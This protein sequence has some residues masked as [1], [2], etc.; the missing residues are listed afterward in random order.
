MS[1]VAIL[2]AVVLAF[3]AFKFLMGLLRIGVVIAIIIVLIV[4][5]QQGSF[6]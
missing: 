1:W 4:M 2:I 6:G 3:I 5:F